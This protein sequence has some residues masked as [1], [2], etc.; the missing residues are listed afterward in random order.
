MSHVSWFARSSAV[1]SQ[2][3]KFGS[4]LA[5][6]LA[7]LA[8]A[9]GPDAS[10]VTIVNYDGT[11]G[12]QGTSLA[13]QPY[14]GATTSANVAFGGG[15]ATDRQG[16]RPFSETTPLVANSA[17]YTGP[18]VYGAYESILFDQ[19][20]GSVFKEHLLREASNSLVIL[21][22]NFNPPNALTAAVSTFYFFNASPSGSSFDASSQL[23]YTTATLYTAAT[24]RWVVK[25]GGTYY[26]SNATFAP[27]PGS[28]GGTVT[29]SG[30]NAST[31]WATYSPSTAGGTVLNF[32]QG[33]A[34]FAPHEFTNVTGAG[35]YFEN[36]SFT[37]GTAPQMD[38]LKFS[39]TAV[40]EPGSL[41]LVA[42]AGLLA[43]RRR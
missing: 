42:A 34:V 36:D 9:A 18:S 12:V 13:D 25:D 26:I 30:P 24:G 5:A 6:A 40:P 14:A 39:V 35:L 33:A 19:A 11:S 16:L 4:G 8:V 31:T 15:A 3:A 17:Q 32:N 27:A 22:S 20:S 21:R 23:S 7:V 41:G 2:R 38:V 1:G 37:G 28:P 29:L 10:A 43:R